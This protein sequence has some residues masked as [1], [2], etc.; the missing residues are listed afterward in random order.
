MYRWNQILIASHKSFF[1]CFG[2][3]GNIHLIYIILST[4]TFRNKSSYLQCIQSFAHCFCIT[5]SFI[6]IYLMITDTQILRETCFSLIFPN[7]FCFCVQSTIMF[8]IL[9]DILIIVMFP[10]PHRNITNWKYV[11][12]MAMGP[13]VWGGFI[14]I[15]G[16]QG[17]EYIA[18]GL[19]NSF[20]ALK[21]PVKRVLAPV[22][23]GSN[24]L[25]LVVFLI[26]ILVF[27]KKGQKNTESQK[28]MR[29]LKVSAFLFILSNYLS[30]FATNIF[31]FLGLSG[32]DLT[33]MIGNISIST[34]FSYSHTFYTIIW[35]SKEY[36]K[37]FIGLYS[38]SA[39]PQT[40]LFYVTSPGKNRAPSDF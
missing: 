40:T 4:P 20:M 21:S 3:F 15:W 6:D 23:V 36:R 31:I 37:R 19:C 24:S 8:F 27:W 38:K 17:E 12:V 10:L 34:M 1:I 16:F 32:E 33:N 11:A 35:R 18:I 5:S 29:H 7:I 22:T 28:I 2:L 25:S 26:L 9:L 39:S 14:V 13:V 30:A